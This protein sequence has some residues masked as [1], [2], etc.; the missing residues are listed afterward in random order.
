[1]KKRY[2]LL[3]I[4]LLDVKPEIW[5]EFVVPSDITL[6]RLHDVIQII[7]GWHDFHIH[8]FI[9][10]KNRFSEF[11][12]ME[13][14][15]DI[16]FSPEF[17]L[18]EFI[19]RK[20]SKFTY[21]YDFGDLWKHSVV[22]ENSNFKRESDLEVYCID[23]ERA[24]PPEDIGGISGYNRLVETINNPASENFENIMDWIENGY[25]SE[26]Y[27]VKIVNWLLMK[28]Y[29]WSRDRFLDWSEDFERDYEGDEE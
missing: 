9:F 6:D 23:G 8:E 2:Y 14:Q 20:G 1:M 26:S 28:Y 22:L 3:K 10:G 15:E 29:L 18:N 11:I 13:E 4:T 27:D 16:L 25:D 12:D 19:K 24:C 7:M 17:R 21:L 5:R